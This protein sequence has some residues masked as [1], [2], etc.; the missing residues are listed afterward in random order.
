MMYNEVLLYPTSIYNFKRNN[1]GYKDAKMGGQ[2]S[3]LQF[4]SETYLEFK[5]YVIRLQSNNEVIGAYINWKLLKVE[6]FVIS[7]NYFVYIDIVNNSIVV[8]LQDNY[9][10]L[11]VAQYKVLIGI[12][13]NGKFESMERI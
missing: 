6:S 9:E 11:N 5:D 8:K 3:L 7:N 10:A 1:I 13:V 12:I 2:V 4:S